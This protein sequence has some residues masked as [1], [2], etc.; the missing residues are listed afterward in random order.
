V[1]TVQQRL[2]IALLIIAGLIVGLSIALWIS[3]GVERPTSLLL[4]A[5]TL[6]LLGIVGIT[7]SRGKED[8]S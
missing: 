3:G 8:E 1:K 5:G 4:S 2:S 7:R 6:F